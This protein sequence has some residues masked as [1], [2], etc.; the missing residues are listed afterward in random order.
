MVLLDQ[1]AISG[2]TGPQTT[3]YGLKAAISGLQSSQVEARRSIYADARNALI[4][5]LRAN[6]PAARLG[7]DFAMPSR[8]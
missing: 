5:E 2:P 8:A 6:R 1:K 7:R 4:K 3:R